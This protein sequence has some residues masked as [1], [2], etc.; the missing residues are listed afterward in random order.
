VKAYVSRVG[1]GPFPT[2]LL[3]ADGERLRVTGH[4]F[5][6]TTGRPRRCGWY[7]AVIARY[8]ARINGVTDFILTKLD[9][10]T[11]WDQIP[12]CVGY[13][14]GGVRY[15]EMPMTQTDFHHARPILEFFP[16]WVEDITGAR[17]LAD[18]PPN[19]QAYVRALEKMSGAPF[20]AVGVG[21]GRDAIIQL[22]PLVD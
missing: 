19:A 8:A 15:D 18:L 4:E 12:V 17:S 7:D 13:D 3:D 1:E 9:V 11:G 6:T 20:S 10:L 22:R 5:G 2:E 21:P 14:I 16:G